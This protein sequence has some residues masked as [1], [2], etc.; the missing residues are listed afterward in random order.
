MYRGTTIVAVRGPEGRAAIA[1]D[2]QVT[3]GDRIVKSGA[4]KVR[5]LHQ[6]RVL[7]GFAGSTAD[8][9]S[10]F[11]L[12]EGQLDKHQGHLARAAVEMTKAWRTDRILR[13]LEAVLLVLDA[14]EIFLISGNGDVLAPDGDFAAIGSGGAMAEAA[15]RA[16]AANTELGPEALCREALKATAAVCLYTNDRISVL[17]LD[18]EGEDRR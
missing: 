17:S 16:L 14:K 11:E 4:C 1:G 12:F 6:G 15:L 10:L 9:L 5:R 8:A 13:R 2:G 7:A 18:G 3:L